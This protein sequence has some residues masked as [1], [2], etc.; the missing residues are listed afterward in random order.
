MNGGLKWWVEVAKSIEITLKDRTIANL[1]KPGRYTFGPGQD[2]IYLIAKTLSDGGLSK[3]WNQKVH[4]K[5]AG[6]NGKANPKELG[7]GKYPGVSVADAIRE[8]ESNVALAKE[9]VDPRAPIKKIPKFKTIALTLVKEYCKT[10]KGSTKPRWA[11]SSKR[12]KMSHLNNHCF[13]FIG[14]TQV[15]QIG[16]RELSFLISVHSKTPSVTISIVPFM[17]E[18]FARCVFED[19]IEANPIDDAF[20][21]Q[22][23]RNTGDTEHFPAP[24]QSGL[25]AAFAE[26]DNKTNDVAVRA[27]VKA[28]I[29]SA[30]R[31][32]SAEDAEWDEIQW[33]EIRNEEDWLDEGW[34]AVDWDSVDGS[35]KTVIWRIPGEHMKKGKPFNVPVSRQFLEILRTM[36][37]IRGEGK[38]DPKLIFASSSGGAF[39]RSTGQD[40]LQSLGLDSDTPGKKPTLHGCRSVLRTWGKKRGVP[41]DVAEAALSHDTGS[42]LVITYMRWDLLAPR[43]IFMQKYADFATGYATESA[44]GKGSAEWM[45]VEPEVQAQIDAERRRADETERRAVH[46]ERRAVHAERRADRLEAELAEMRREVGKTNELVQTLVERTVA[47]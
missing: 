6:K 45:W 33:K 39:A 32:H 27:L 2:G 29:L 28:I 37:A 23:P 12:M 19:F 15:D 9:G 40:L 7:L 5:G 44:T 46:A 16:K 11:P 35:T 36:R 4:I 8:A 24:L 14:D 10:I 22:L 34:E 3:V 21:S 47:G 17:K 30:V 26:I 38:R 13:P 18:I 43:A 41:D 42:Q 31:P 1:I 20:M 25:P